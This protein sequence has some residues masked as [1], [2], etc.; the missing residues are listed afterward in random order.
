L[1]TVPKGAL[2]LPPILP[3]GKQT[4]EERSIRLSVACADVLSSLNAMAPRSSTGQ[5]T[6]P[7]LGRSI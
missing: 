4:I 6:S 2:L 5:A 1:K 7:D 3:P